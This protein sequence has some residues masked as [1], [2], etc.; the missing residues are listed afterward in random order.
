MVSTMSDGWKFEQMVNIGSSYSYGTEDQAEFL[1]WYLKSC[2][3]LGLGWVQSR[4]T[5]R[6]Y[7][8]FPRKHTHNFIRI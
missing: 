4:A 7:N 2:T 5:K 3:L 1:V 8:S 6:R